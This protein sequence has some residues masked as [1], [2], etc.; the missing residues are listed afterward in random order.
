M[1]KRADADLLLPSENSPEQQQDQRSKRRDTNGPEVE[2]TLTHGT[3]AEPGAEQPAE[4]R[5]NDPE[6]DGENAAGR[7]AAG[8]DELRQRAGD[9]SEEEPEEPEGHDQ[10]SNGARPSARDGQQTAR[11][12]GQPSSVDRVLRAADRS[13]SYR[14]VVPRV[15][16][17]AR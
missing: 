15:R 4:Q 13:L 6:E 12:M 16:V 9:Q 14:V 3:P 5:A 17:V 8:H 10:R 11:S 2:L 1:A 7:V